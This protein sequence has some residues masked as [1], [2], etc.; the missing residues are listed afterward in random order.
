MRLNIK[1]DADLTVEQ[2]G[3]IANILWGA[4]ND[5]IDDAKGFGVW[6]EGDEAAEVMAEAERQYQRANSSHWPTLTAEADS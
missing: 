4:V 6:F 5:R 2:A 1:V 3:Q